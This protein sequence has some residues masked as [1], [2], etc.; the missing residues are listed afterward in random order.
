MLSSST[1]SASSSLQSSS[2]SPPFLDLSLKPLLQQLSLAALLSLV[3]LASAR[4]SALSLWLRP[5]RTDRTQLLSID[6]LLTR[7]NGTPEELM[8][9]MLPLELLVEMDPERRLGK[10]IDLRR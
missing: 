3:D 10:R 1:L 7:R 2:S 5:L 4:P 6:S 9:H 8:Q